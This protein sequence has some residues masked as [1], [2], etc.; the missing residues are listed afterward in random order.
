MAKQEIRFSIDEK[1]EARLTFL[2]DSSVPEVVRDAREYRAWADDLCPDTKRCLPLAL[3]A[4][5][6]YR[7]MIQQVQ[8]LRLDEVLDDICMEAMRAWRKLPQTAAVKRAIHLAA[9]MSLRLGGG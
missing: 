9:N 6:S 2:A 4:V 8:A 7:A 3:G 5:K 1:G